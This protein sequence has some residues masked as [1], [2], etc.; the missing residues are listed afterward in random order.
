LITPLNLNNDSSGYYE[1]N[2]Q[3]LLGSAGNFYF[4]FLTN[5][6]NTGTSNI[7]FINKRPFESNNTTTFKSINVNIINDVK[8]QSASAF[9]VKVTINLLI[10]YL[11]LI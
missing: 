7:N 4:S 9:L 11:I 2:N 5:N 6:S 8:T 3:N 1:S 10:I